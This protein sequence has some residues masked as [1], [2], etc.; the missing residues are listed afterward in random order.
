MCNIYHRF[1]SSFL[2]DLI[3]QEG[4][5][6]LRAHTR[7]GKHSNVRL[8]NCYTHVPQDGFQ[9][10]FKTHSEMIM[11][12]KSSFWSNTN[13][14]PWAL[15][16]LRDRLRAADCMGV[17]WSPQKSDGPFSL[18]YRIS[19]GFNSAFLQENMKS[20]FPNFKRKCF[21]TSHSRWCPANFWSCSLGT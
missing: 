16:C 12:H 20:P 13:S 1:S 18:D 21:P 19:K 14:V 10:N 17:H 7:G 15:L 3:Q 5:L 4:C 11:C 8:K 6:E 9:P 2:Y